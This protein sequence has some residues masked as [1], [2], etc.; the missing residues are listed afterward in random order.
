MADSTHP[1]QSESAYRGAPAACEVGRRPP[2]SVDALPM[3]CYARRTTAMR[4]RHAGKAMTAPT[5]A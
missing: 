3:A 1:V 5:P 4:P 2:A